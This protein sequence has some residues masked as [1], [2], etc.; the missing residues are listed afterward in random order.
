MNAIASKV[1]LFGSSPE[2]RREVIYRCAESLLRGLLNGASDSEK[3]AL[4]QSLEHLGIAEI[5]GL[6][7]SADSLHSSGTGIVPTQTNQDFQ[8]NDTAARINTE[9]AAIDGLSQ[10]SGDNAA[11]P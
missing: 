7:A 8:N 1:N 3:Q 4:F 10:R 9:T 11:H 6:N 5:R 2:Q